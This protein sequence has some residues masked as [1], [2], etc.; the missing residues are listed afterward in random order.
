MSNELTKIV[1]AYAGCEQNHLQDRQQQLQIP[2]QVSAD[3]PLTVPAIR[4]HADND[5]FTVILKGLATS[6]TDL[7]WRQPD[8]KDK[9]Y[10]ANKLADSIPKKFPSIR[11]HEIPV[12]FAAGIRGRYG[13]FMGL[14]VVSFENFIEAHL[15]SETREQFAKEVL[16]VPS[17]K[18]P[19]NETKFNTAKYN[20]LK[21]F[22]DK[23]A[24]HDI[25]LIA[26]V[27]YTFLDALKLIPFSAKDKWAFV[28]QA[29]EILVN[30]FTFQITKALSKPERD[31]LRRKIESVNEGT[32]VQQILN[33]SKRVALC[34]Y[35]DD[36]EIEEINLEK[37]IDSKKEMFLDA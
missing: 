4:S 11:L 36:V 18:E 6:Y 23:K 3:N 8:E 15:T 21:A 20:A 29:K 9:N 31:R 2:F 22:N 30:D 26:L 28:D 12:A 24:G 37:L 5:I 34:A 17:G 35:Y 16:M 25:S 7:G 19:D 1:T 10:V 13:P 33:M 32:A 27:V 14:S